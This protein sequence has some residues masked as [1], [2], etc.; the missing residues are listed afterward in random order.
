MST[1]VYADYAAATPLRP[2]A[3]D[4]MLEALAAGLGNPSSVHDAGAR[5]RARL[6]AAREEVAAALDAHP[7]EIVFTSGA[8]EANNLALAGAL[9]ATGAHRHLAVAA[10]EHASVLAPARALAARG[11]R[12]TVLPADAD[13]GSDREAIERAAPDVLS[14]ALVNAETGVVLD[15]TGLGAA[16]RARGGLVHSDAAQA[17]TYVPL[18][19]DDLG[20][21]LLTLSS[22]K[23]GGPPGIGALYVRRGTA[24][25]P[26]HHGGPQE[27][28]LRAG[29]EN[30]PAI[31]GFATALAIARA[32][33]ARERERVAAL[34]ARLRAAITACWPG[35]RF[36]TSPAVPVAPHLV[37]VGLPDAL[38]ED[39]VAALDLE[40]VAVST[41]SACAAGAAEPSHVL[42][43]MGRSRDEAARTLRI[44]L[45]WAS[46]GADVDAIAG[47]LARVR[48]RIGARSKEAAWP[49]HES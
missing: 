25:A 43:A 47:A 16:V 7:L 5:A 13:G 11:H 15:V 21:D 9:D 40:G 45:G 35:V 33:R 23:L 6:E 2:E 3:R 14:L 26:L 49:A 4:A 19:V 34:A 44:S 36:A 32:E 17:A 39:V 8:T 24:L 12:L 42:Q 22:G 31:V 27:H 41:G 29:T 1:D 28:G 10:T 18:A 20:V 30:V 48:T 37:N 46:T 38:G